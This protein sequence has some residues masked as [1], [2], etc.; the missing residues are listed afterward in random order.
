MNPFKNY[1]AFT[2][3]CAE[4]SQLRSTHCSHVLPI[5]VHRCTVSAYRSLPYQGLRASITVKYPSIVI[6]FI[7]R[8]LL[9]SLLFLTCTGCSH[10][11]VPAWA[12][13]AAH[14]PAAGPDPSPVCVCALRS[15]GVPPELAQRQCKWERLLSGPGALPWLDWCD[16]Y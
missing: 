11:E 15:T 7:S 12:E 13:K 14:V 8:I 10:S 2:A 5:H 3:K 9:S 16:S 4:T 6:R 1:I